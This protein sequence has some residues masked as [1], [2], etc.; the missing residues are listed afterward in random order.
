M[1]DF[2]QEFLDET[3]VNGKSFVDQKWGIV[4]HLL[5]HRRGMKS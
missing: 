3:D 5:V 2:Q 4:D 1:A